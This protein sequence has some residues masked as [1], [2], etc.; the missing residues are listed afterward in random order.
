MCHRLIKFC[1][2]EY[3]PH[4]RI[5]IY[6]H[7][8]IQA[9]LHTKSKFSQIWLPVSGNFR[10]CIKST[11]KIN[12]GWRFCTSQ[13]LC[14]RGPVNA[15]QCYCAPGRTRWWFTV[16]HAKNMPDS[17]K[18]HFIPNILN[19]SPTLALYARNSASMGRTNQSHAQKASGVTTSMQFVISRSGINWSAARY[20]PAARDLETTVL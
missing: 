10:R 8:G 9:L 4:W 15:Q 17:L 14:K 11:L 18:L 19:L 13:P 16:S 6:C 1:I 20:R 2:L 3:F 7:F 12:W 5:K